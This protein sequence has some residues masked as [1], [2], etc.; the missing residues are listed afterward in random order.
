MILIGFG[1]GIAMEPAILHATVPNTDITLRSPPTPTLG[2]T[3]DIQ[4]GFILFGI[5]G[6]FVAGL[7]YKDKEKEQRIIA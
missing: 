5:L 7:G 1:V 3:V 4:V 6:S 2:N